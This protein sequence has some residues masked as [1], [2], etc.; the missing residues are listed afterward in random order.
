MQIKQTIHQNLYQL[1]HILHQLTDEEYVCE[2]EILNGQTIG[3]HV[4]HIVE[5]YQCLMN[6]TTYVCYDERERN[7]LLETSTS[8]TLST[9]EI[10]MDKIDA[11]DF[12]QNIQLKQLVN[13][14]VFKVNSTIGR[15]LIYCIDH[16]IHHFA[17]IKMALEN[18]F[19]A[20]DLSDDFGIA[21]STLKYN[22]ENK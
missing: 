1:E 18:H 2:L 21:Y 11:L 7:L 22:A 4:R 3:K 8:F 16:S 20:M 17:I 19:S 14:E 6:A 5:F 13:D 15:E 10:I 12:N 9:I